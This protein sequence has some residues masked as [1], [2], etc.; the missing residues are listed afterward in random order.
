MAGALILTHRMLDDEYKR[1]EMITHCIRHGYSPIDFDNYID[2]Y[3]PIPKP[4]SPSICKRIANFF[5]GNKPSTVAPLPRI[6][7]TAVVPGYTQIPN[8]SADIVGPEGQ[9]NLSGTGWMQ[10][11]AETET[12][13]HLRFALRHP[14]PQLS[15][16]DTEWAAI[17]THPII[18]R[19]D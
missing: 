8:D 18:Q 6:N 2:N 14:I 9:V 7:F 5:M 13:H 19:G 17:V 15:D 16:I 11:P 1:E 3:I 10:P 4:K 12:S